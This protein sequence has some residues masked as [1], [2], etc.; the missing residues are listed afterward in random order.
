MLAPL[1]G[2]SSP[3]I[4]LINTKTGKRC[5]PPYSTFR[6]SI[7]DINTESRQFS[8][9]KKKNNILKNDTLV[10]TTYD[11]NCRKL[12]EQTLPMFLES[13]DPGGPDKTFT[14]R[15]SNFAYTKI[16]KQKNDEDRTKELHLYDMVAMKDRIVAPNFTLR[17]YKEVSFMQWISNDEI[18]LIHGN[19]FII[20]I[21]SGEQ[22][23]IYCEEE[24]SMPRV[25]LSPDCTR[26]AFTAT[27]E[28]RNTVIKIL[29]L[30]SGKIIAT[31]GSETGTRK[32]LPRWSLDGRELAYVDGKQM[33]VYYIDG[34][35][36]KILKTLPPDYLYYDLV[37]GKDIIGYTDGNINKPEARKTFHIINAKTGKPLKNI[38]LAFTGD[39]WLLDNDCTFICETG[40]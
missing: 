22:R 13:C 39:I 26:L 6:Q 32:Q 40:T 31:I 23:N 3:D 14:I 35:R 17:G 24:L 8:T 27:G 2:Y 12:K 5:S 38:T 7:V 11:E 1:A 18:I 37:F 25:A 36:E 30:D 19:I 4:T 9:L 34:G 20:N 15:N 16:V 28:R 21:V 29:A 10:Y 33:K